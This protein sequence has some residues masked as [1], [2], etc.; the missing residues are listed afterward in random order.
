MKLMMLTSELLTA[1]RAFG[2]IVLHAAT[3]NKVKHIDARMRCS[4][5]LR[6][7]CS[8]DAIIPTL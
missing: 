4:D 8:L 1:K 5:R 3:I 7:S 2:I 6:T